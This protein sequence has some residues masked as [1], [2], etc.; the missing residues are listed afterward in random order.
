MRAAFE[1]R[2]Q[3]RCTSCSPASRASPA[4]SPQGAFY[5][6]PEPVGLPRPADP[7]PHRRRPPLELA[8]L[9]LDEA[10]V[11]IVPGEAFDAPGYARLSYALGD[12]DLGEGC[13]RIADLLAEAS[14]AAEP[15]VL[16]YGSWPTPITSELVVRS[17]RLPNGLRVRR[18]RRVVVGGPARGGRPHRGPAPRR[19]RRA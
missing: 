1:R 14:D 12:D 15:T 10:K 2:G 6:L 9:L 3:H 18:R 4:S 5:A 11:A 19:R 13:R 17:A 8:E 16:P 7:R